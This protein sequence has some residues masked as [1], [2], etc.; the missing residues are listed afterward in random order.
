IWIY[1]PSCANRGRGIRVVTGV[2]ELRELTGIVQKY[3][4]NPL[5][6]TPEGYKFD[7]RVY[8]LVARNYPTTLAFYHPGYVRMALKPY[9]VAT[10]ESLEDECVHLTNASIQKKHTV[11]KEE[12]NKE[13]QVQGIE[14]IAKGLDDIGKSDSAEYMRNTLDHEIKLCLVDLLKAS[15]HIFLKRHGYFDLL[16]CDFMLSASN[17]LSLLEVNTNPALTLD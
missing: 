11:Y 9:S 14:A 1:K 16:G 6:L 15:N 2:E 8:L 12:G 17:K 7:I 5:L 4:R 10:K 13:A 3:I